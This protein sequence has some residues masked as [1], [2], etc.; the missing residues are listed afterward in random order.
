M[1]RTSWG[2]ALKAAGVEH[3]TRHDLRHTAITWGMSRGMS[4]WEAA[5][6]FGVSVD[7]IERVYGHHS[8]SY[9]ADAAAKMSESGRSSQFEAVRRQ[10]DGR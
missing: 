1:I 6:F 7:L 10:A 5:G 4:T 2:T 3:C 8:P 9:L